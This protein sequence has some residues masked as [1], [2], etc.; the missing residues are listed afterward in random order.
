MTFSEFEEEIKNKDEVSVKDLIRLFEF[1]ETNE[2]QMSA[3]FNALLQYTTLIPIQCEKVYEA[4]F[5]NTLETWKELARGFSA[6]I[7]L[8]LLGD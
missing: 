7:T 1:N 2:K 4:K 8:D 5:S 3:F 6:V